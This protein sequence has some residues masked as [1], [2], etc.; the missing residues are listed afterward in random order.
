[1][2]PEDLRIEPEQRTYPGGQHVGTSPNGI[3]VTHLPT[4][5]K[6]FCNYERSQIK[7]KKI[8]L[9]MIEW[10]LVQLELQ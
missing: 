8:A 5:L 10:G 4:G 7:N 3:H 6:A 1:M 2:K 9:D